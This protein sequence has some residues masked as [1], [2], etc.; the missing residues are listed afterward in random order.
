MARKLGEKRHSLALR[1]PLSGGVITLY[2]RR[3]TTEERVAY[4]MSAFRL[5]DGRR[6][7]ALGRTRLEFGLQILEGFEPGDFLV[8]ADEGETPLDPGRHPDWKEQLAAE[9]PDLVACLGQQIFEGLRV[10]TPG[11]AGWE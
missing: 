9:A 6:R 7:L 8:D 3:P 4:Q 11:E 10:L 2:Y 1:D 5:E